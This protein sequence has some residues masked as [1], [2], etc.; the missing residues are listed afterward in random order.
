[1]LQPPFWPKIGVFEFGFL[2]PKTMMLNNKHNSKSGKKERWEK[3]ISKRKQDREPKKENTF[4][5]NQE[6]AIL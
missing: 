3:E 6:I 5:E 2:K 1:M 4:I